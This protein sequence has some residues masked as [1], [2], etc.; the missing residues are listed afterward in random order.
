MAIHSQGEQHYLINFEVIRSLTNFP[1]GWQLAPAAS[2]DFTLIILLQARKITV[3]VFPRGVCQVIV[4]SRGYLENTSS[5]SFIKSL[6]G[7]KL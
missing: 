6:W 5:Y 7:H 1:G 3:G 4:T 2:E